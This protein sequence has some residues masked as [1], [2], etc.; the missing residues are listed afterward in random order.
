MRCSLAAFATCVAL[1][2]SSGGALAWGTAGHVVVARIAARELTPSARAQVEALLHGPAADRMAAVASV[3]DWLGRALPDTK[4]W[5]YV[6]I[7]LSSPGYDAGRDCP[8]GDCI[9]AAIARFEDVLR[10]RHAA[11]S[12]RA[13]ALMWL[14]HLLGD[15]HQPLHCADDHD[16]GGNAVTLWDGDRR[17]NLHSIWDRSPGMLPEANGG[18]A[19]LAGALERKIGPLQQGDWKRG[20]PVRW[21]TESFRIARDRIYAERAKGSIEP[22]PMVVRLQLEKAGVRLGALINQSLGTGGR[23]V[24]ARD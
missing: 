23:G 7:E 21:A 8:S 15:L 16:R 3:P 24:V 12:A 20:T 11:K 10:D 19:A 2:A 5:H 1:L 13:E 17:T 9:V 6:N 14:I 22:D 4:P 18:A